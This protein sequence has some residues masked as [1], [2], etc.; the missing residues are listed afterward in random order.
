MSVLF[1]LIRLADP[2]GWG[3]ADMETPCILIDREQNNEWGTLT[4]FSQFRLYNL[5]SGA[6]KPG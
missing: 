5:R 3:D 1:V 2:A 4:S 6:V